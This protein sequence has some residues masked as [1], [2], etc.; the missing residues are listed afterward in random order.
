MNMA[1]ASSP[2]HC[3][4]LAAQHFDQ[5]PA[6]PQSE[7][8][9]QPLQALLGESWTQNPYAGPGPPHAGSFD[10]QQVLQ[11]PG[12]PQSSGVPQA[13]QAFAGV[14]CLQK[15]ISL[16]VGGGVGDG[17]GIGTQLPPGIP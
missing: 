1:S 6:A 3:Q 15:P 17:V 11:S 5:S 8:S 9:L 14:S 16:I 13:P 4:S 2:P 10:F 7:G 12:V